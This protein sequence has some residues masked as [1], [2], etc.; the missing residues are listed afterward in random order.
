MNMIVLYFFILTHAEAGTNYIVTNNSESGTGSLRQAMLDALG[1][2]PGATPHTITFSISG[3]G[4]QQTITLT[5]M[6]GPLPSLYNSNVNGLIIDATTQGSAF[7]GIILVGPG[8]GNGFQLDGRN[9]VEIRGFMIR[10][11][12]NGIYINNG[13][14]NNVIGGSISGQGNCIAGNNAEGV[15]L[16]GA[17]R[18][19]KIVGNIV[20]LV[21]AG[22]S[23]LANNQN[24][25]RVYNSIKT[26]IGGL[27]D[28]ER[29]VVSGNGVQGII[30][31][32][33]DSVTVLNNYVGL[34]ISGTNS[35][36]NN[37][38]G[39]LFQNNSRYGTIGSTVSGKGNVVGGHVNGEG[40]LLEYGC[41]NGKVLGNIV[42]LDKT[43]TVRRPNKVGI[44]LNQSNYGLV[45]N[46]IACAS[47]Q[48]G[49]ILINNLCVNSV[50]TN[51]YVGT[52]KNLAS[53]LGNTA[54]GIF[55]QKSATGTLVQN[56]IVDYN[57]NDGIH[58]LNGALN[59]VVKSNT[60]QYNQM[61]GVRIDLGANANTIGGLSSSDKNVISYNGANGVT[62]DGSTS[63]NN[64]IRKNSI[65][66]NG[67]RGIVLLNGGNNNYPI[68][69]SGNSTNT[70]ILGTATP[71][72]RV[73]IF[74]T[75]T[76]VCASTC[77]PGNN[78]IQGM[79]YITTVTADGAG[80]W[81]FPFSGSKDTI[82]ATASV[83]DAL[84]NNTSEFAI[85]ALCQAPTATIVASGPT[86]FCQGGSVDLSA[87]ITSAGTLPYSYQWYK[88]GVLISGATSSIY[89]ASIS[90]NYSLTINA[91]GGSCSTSVGPVT[92]TVNPRPS[93]PVITGPNT[94]CAPST[95]VDFS[96][97]SIAGATYTWTLPSGATISSGSGTNA[98]KVDFSSAASSGT[99]KVSVT[100]SNGCSD[101]TD[102]TFSVTVN[103][104]PSNP[105]ITGP[106]TICAPS[107]G[108]DFS[109][110]SVVGATYAWTL[111]TGATITSGTGT[112][113]IKVDFAS[114]ASSG[115]V[116]VSVT[117]SNGCSDLTDGALSVIV[118][119][120]PANPT[121]TGPNTICV[122]ATGIDFS[123]A[124][125]A[126]AT[127]TWTLPT[128][129]TIASG[130]G[131]NAIKVDFSS[132]AADGTIQVSVVSSNGCN[133]L[134]D[135]SSSITINSSPSSP[136]I[137]GPSTICAPS[138]GIDYSATFISNAT[139][140]WTL[141]SGATITSG[142]GTNSIKVDFASGAANGPIQVSVSS[143]NGCQDLQG[144]DLN[145]IVNP[146]PQ[147]PTITGPNTI[148]AP[149]TGVDFNTT[150][151]SGATYSWSLP[152]GATIS[153][154]AGTND[155]K[156][157]FTSGASSGTVKVSLID[158]NGCSNLSD[159]TAPI[160]VNEQPSTGNI[161]GPSAI[162]ENSS[163]V[164]FMISPAIN[165][166]VYTWTLPSGATISSD[167]TKDSIM[168]DFTSAPGN[169]IISVYASMNGCDDLTPSTS[170]IRI[171]QSVVAKAQ[172][173]VSNHC[174]STIDITAEVPIVGAGSWSVVQPTT[175]TLDQVNSPNCS[176]SNLADGL[177]IFIWTVVN[178]ACSAND[179]VYVDKNPT[180]QTASIITPDT[181][182]CRGAIGIQAMAIS[183]PGLSGLWTASPSGINFTDSASPV[184]DA[185]NF[186]SDTT[187]LYW[188]ISGTCGSNTDS[189]LVTLSGSNFAIS[190]SI[191][192]DT[193]CVGS[194]VVMEVKI[195]GNA[196]ASYSY[197]YYS[198][199]N[200]IKSIS[201]NNVLHLEP[202]STGWIYYYVE[203][204]DNQGCI[205]D[206]MAQDSVYAVNNQ[207]LIMPNLITPN[208]DGHNDC[209]LIKDE[210]GSEILP[211]SVFNIYNRWGDPVYRINNYKNGDF[212][213]SILS[214]GIYYY[215]I[216]TG[217]GADEYKGWIQIISN[218]ESK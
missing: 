198:S 112:N 128:G 96:T 40:I 135:G 33:S 170:T 152:T 81:S 92:V 161:T 163:N 62:V 36:M 125:I 29:N 217:C 151:V 104:R 137:T 98:I 159:G 181:S 23:S 165:G 186:K 132:G 182:I 73:E 58:I 59:S 202:K 45:D 28:T 124:Y 175:A 100:N 206:H 218:T 213:G 51:N 157:D 37:S 122:P 84:P 204:K 13:A 57:N 130:S 47:M 102:G 35:I 162:C 136:V 168:V 149:S 85:C 205:S 121:I 119:A 180:T 108:N 109:T 93:N 113:A 78:K 70:V 129:A 3:G 203:A 141:P 115:T 208:G 46:N 172:S 77:S 101:L 174:G 5:G 201:A 197:T 155:I 207:S 199:E 133:D 123:T 53:G 138:T 8:W 196:N 94:I 15:F 22:N 56:N 185:S 30:V 39:I 90:G 95:G 19:N 49:G 179:S 134:I 111:P 176:V 118:N 114:G 17:G 147:D 169:Y 126:G 215:F 191:A 131:T 195:N 103:V 91:G 148:C 105:V 86:T 190:A 12:D 69:I 38:K 24:G 26:V 193:L 44:N 106:N 75:G 214:D 107:T 87:N 210:N 61:D 67:G 71:N 88:D 16:D 89:T 54:D 7:P 27:L 189:V 166:A 42:G 10:G 178:G 18:N 150:L 6:T 99:I 72:S 9:G 143:S 60:I 79:N 192:Q 160:I 52:N 156:V 63:L 194:P 2:N 83:S 177:S 41:D 64:S 173:D 117:T 80:N 1:T 11:F 74:G 200:S 140:T 144:V 154:G 158:G 21:P 145:I 110:T 68:T 31:S 14:Y 34:D 209:V 4:T 187:K 48:E 20:G 76:L 66:C 97:A 164:K 146:R 171:D 82:T 183:S 65:F 25:I 184:T 153:A 55:I 142:L 50:V 139:Y 212:C 116:K 32:S 211:G 188:T 167:P 127:F 43:A 216:K 120:R